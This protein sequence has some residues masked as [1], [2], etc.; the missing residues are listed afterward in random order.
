MLFD[1]CSSISCCYLPTCITIQLLEYSTSVRCR[2]HDEGCKE[3]RPLS[4]DLVVKWSTDG[5][6]SLVAIFPLVSLS[7]SCPPSFNSLLQ[8]VFIRLIKSFNVTEISQYPSFFLFR[9]L[10]FHS[11]PSTHTS[12]L[13][14]H[15]GFVYLKVSTI[16]KHGCFKLQQL[17]FLITSNPW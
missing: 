8:Y 13:R 3:S 6:P 11:H 16:T 14:I 15:I 10:L 4:L 5:R 17:E 9:R 7:T 2:L 1:R 12:E